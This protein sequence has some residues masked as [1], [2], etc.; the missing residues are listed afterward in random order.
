M[1]LCSKFSY[2]WIKS[3]SY[4]SL[5]YYFSIISALCRSFASSSRNCNCDEILPYMNSF[6]SFK[7]SICCS[8]VLIFVSADEVGF[9]G[10]A[11]SK[12]RS[13]TSLEL[14]VGCNLLTLLRLIR[15]S[16]WTERSYN[17]RA[18]SFCEFGLKSAD[19]RLLFSYRKERTD[20]LTEAWSWIGLN[21]G[22]YKRVPSSFTSMLSH[23][24]SRLVLRYPMSIYSRQLDSGLGLK[25]DRH[26]IWSG[27]RIFVLITT[28][29]ELS[30]HFLKG[31]ACIDNPSNGCLCQ[32]TPKLSTPTSFYLWSFSAYSFI[33]Q[34]NS[35]ARPL[36]VA[37]D[38]GERSAL[39]WLTVDLILY[40][41]AFCLT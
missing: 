22:G 8:R 25:S 24:S 18:L 10:V 38:D 31:T 12:L 26:S 30:M 17:L 23:S 35:F 37:D 1:L 2:S 13:L 5:R 20:F 4:R 41:V 6:S 40:G 9:W 36:A 3:I 7:T 29:A 21:E 11:L 34:V 39:F 27:S 14:F 16:L 33:A 19:W 32:S 15:L 28:T